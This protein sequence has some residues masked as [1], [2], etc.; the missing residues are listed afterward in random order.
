MYTIHRDII[1]I[2]IK[3]IWVLRIFFLFHGFIYIWSCINFET[4]S[5]FFV[6]IQ[7]NLYD[8]FLNELLNI[9]VKYSIIQPMNL[10]W[11]SVIVHS[12]SKVGIEC[13]IKP[14]ACEWWC[15]FKLGARH[16]NM[17]SKRKKKTM[18]STKSKSNH[19]SLCKRINIRIMAIQSNGKQ[20]LNMYEFASHRL[21]LFFFSFRFCSWN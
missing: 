9:R 2:W 10:I 16:H 7:L 4:Y 18:N 13:I 6:L 11:S 1:F 19:T 17:P 14:S 12:R 20:H 21:I 5:N 3:F 15:A 8:S